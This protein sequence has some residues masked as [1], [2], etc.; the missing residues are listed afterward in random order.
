MRKLLPNLTFILYLTTPIMWRRERLGDH[1]WIADINPVYHMISLVREPLLG[2]TPSALS[3][4][5]A[6]GLAVVG[7]MIGIALLGAFRRRIPLW[8]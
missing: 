7:N 3:W 4:W 8:L 6:I 2:H 5:V 1:T